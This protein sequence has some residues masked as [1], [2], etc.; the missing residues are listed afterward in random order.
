MTTRKKGGLE[1]DKKLLD[2]IADTIL[3]YNPKKRSLRKRR[4]G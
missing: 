1:I 4:R 3:A 2:R